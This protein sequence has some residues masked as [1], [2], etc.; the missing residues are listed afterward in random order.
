M[1]R[2]ALYRCRVGVMHAGWKLWKIAKVDHIKANKNIW[3]PK[4]DANE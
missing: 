4:E 3:T 2:R 1:D